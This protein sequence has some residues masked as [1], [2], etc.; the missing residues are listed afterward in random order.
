MHLTTTGSQFRLLRQQLRFKGIRF[1]FELSGRRHI[2]QTR[3]SLVTM[4]GKQSRTPATYYRGGTSR[5]IMFRRSDLPKDQK[6]W[7]RIFCGALGSPDPHGRQLDGL[8]TGVGS[9]SKIC[10]IEPSER[11]D[12]DVDYT[13]VQIGVRDGA[14]D[15]SSNCGNMSS[16]VGPFA[17]DSGIVEAEPNGEATVRIFNTNTNKLIKSTFQVQGG[18]TVVDGPLAIAGVAGTGAKI[19]LAFQKPGGS[20]TGKVLP[21]GRPL[22]EFDGIKASCV[23]VGNPCVFVQAA[24]M[25]VDGT[26]LPDAGEAHPD[27][28]TRLEKLRRKAAVAMGIAPDEASVP[29]AAPKIIMVSPPSPYKTLSG[30]KFDT[31]S[32]DLIVRSL[33]GLGFHRALQITAG[34]ATAAAAKIEGTVAAMNVSKKPVDADGI[35]LGHP[36]GTLLVTAKFDADGV[37][38]EAT[39][40]RTARRL[41]EGN[42]FWR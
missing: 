14:V 4:A 34:L 35:T 25:G 12:A 8:G 37:V 7:G 29:E 15:Y 1:E 39:V 40:F 24:D 38:S 19:E 17:V 41:M 11:P 32:S 31:G 33:T 23:D 28:I 13:F 2:V 27:I 10:V 5:G 20:R 26:I 30:E 36:S 3:Q 6:E 21:T 18:E 42:V 9:L 16:A 22:D